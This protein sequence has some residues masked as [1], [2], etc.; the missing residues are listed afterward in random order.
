V[1]KYIIIRSL[2]ISDNPLKVNK[3]GFPLI[4]EVFITVSVLNL[5]AI[6]GRLCFLG[7]ATTPCCN[8]HYNTSLILL[9]SRHHTTLLTDMC[10]YA[11]MLS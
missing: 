10:K 5:Q 1:D 4:I 9:A 6:S 11:A 2:N 7:I 3:D 8:Y